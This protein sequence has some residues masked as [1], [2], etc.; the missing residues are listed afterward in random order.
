MQIVEYVTEVTKPNEKRLTEF[1]DANL[2]SLEFR[3]FSRAPIYTDMEEMLFADG[4]QESL[5]ELGP[6]DPFIQT[7][8][9][10]RAPAD[11]AKELINGT[12]IGDVDFRRVTIKGGEKAVAESTDPL[13]VLARKLD[14]EPVRGGNGLKQMS[15]A[16]D[17]LPLKNLEK[18]DSLLTGKIRIPMQHSRFGCHTER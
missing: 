4:L 12:K 16:F 2:A 11:V 15:P 18:R 17:P 1:Q 3:M 5:D 10:G 6:N 8:L 14:P 13:I 9:G 7:V